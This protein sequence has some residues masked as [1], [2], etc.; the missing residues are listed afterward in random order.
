[1]K[2][3]LCV[4]KWLI[5]IFRP[6]LSLSRGFSTMA[7]GLYFSVWSGPNSML[8][9]ALVRFQIILVKSCVGY[10]ERLPAILSAV[11]SNS[12]IA[13]TCHYGTVSFKYVTWHMVVSAR[14]APTSQ[15]LFA[16][17]SV[18]W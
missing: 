2:I 16:K 3:T 6:T 7:P 11:R 18:T 8:L 9:E 15:R 12:N 1:M 5:P 10:S 13:S 17:W 4:I 14:H